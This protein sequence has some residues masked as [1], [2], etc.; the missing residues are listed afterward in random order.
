M[1]SGDKKPG[2]RPSVV[3]DCFP[4][5]AQ[6]YRDGYA[7]VAIDVIRATTTAVTAASLGWRCFPTASLE[8]AVPLAARLPNPLLAGEL[9]GNMPY[10][11][12]MTNSPSEIAMRTDIQRPMILLSSS[13]T[14]LLAEANGC[15]VTYAACLRNHSAQAH[16]LVGRHQHVAVI[17]AGS[18]NEFREEDQLCC[19]WIAEALMQAG[20][21][22]ENAET[23]RI[24]SQW[25]GAKP[26]AFL[27][28]NSVEYLRRTGQVHDLYFTL[29]HVDDLSAV[30]V[31]KDNEIVMT[32]V[33]R[34]QPRRDAA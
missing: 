28:S 13:G 16:H 25:S 1:D 11:F 27:G 23:E 30:F 19:A 18:R 8:T 26:E 9:G 31:L 33:M 29:D 14:Q 3:I 34:E 12:E 22:P 7:I 21:Q 10:G 20:Y 2:A 6:R 4:T 15:D 24:V 5:S 32:P 17:G